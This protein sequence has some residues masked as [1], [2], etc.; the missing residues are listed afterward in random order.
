MKI[1]IFAKTFPRPNLEETLDAVRAHGLSCVQFNLACAGLPSMPDQLEGGVVEWVRREMEA[2]SVQMA[3]ISGTFNMIHPEPHERQAGL[4]RLRVLAA[5]CG[6]L[7]T[8]VITLCTGTRDRQDMWRR[9]PD[10]DNPQAWQD[11]TAC[12]SQALQIAE[13][14]DVV[15]AFEPEVSNVVDTARKGRR[16]LDEMQ[17]PRLK[18]VLDAANLFHQGELVHMPA[19]LV[20]AF[21]LLAEDIVIVHAKDLSHDGAAGHQAA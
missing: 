16:L 2:R 13:E 18:V 20:E 4:R 11:L 19:I 6:R 1:G 14:Y 21:E 3:A 9:H 8:R 17:S 15:L 12:M 10:N 5:A 7:G